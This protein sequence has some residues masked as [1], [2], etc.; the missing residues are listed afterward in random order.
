MMLFYIAIIV[1]LLCFVLYVIDRRMRDEPIDW[2]TALK[3]SVVGGL[4]SGGTGYAMG[5][6][7]VAEVVEKVAEVASKPETQ[8]MF[9]GVPTF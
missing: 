8:E 5:D 6:P 2:M 1:S 7:E 9:V 3:V 4:L